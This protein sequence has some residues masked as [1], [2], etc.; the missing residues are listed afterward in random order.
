MEL[1]GDDYKVRIGETV[2]RR[3]LANPTVLQIPSKTLEIF[4]ARDFLTPAECAGLIRLIDRNRMPSQLL[5]PTSDPEF[6]TSESCNLDPDDPMVIQVERKIANLMGIEPSHGETI[7]GQRY[8]VGQ[9]FKEHHDFFH[10]GEPYWDEMERCGGQRTWTAMVFLNAP[11]SGGQTAFP[12]AA[13]KVAP[14][15]GN[16][17]TW[18]NMTPDGHP[19]RV[20]LHQGLPVTEGVKYIITKWH[21]ERPWHPSAV[22]TY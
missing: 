18:N 2:R 1:E 3:L 4:V 8:A 14:R 17:L 16:L 13:I 10:I 7:Q 12:E 6:R 21:R 20:S 15:V 9:Q 22:P 11:A 5:S 19:N